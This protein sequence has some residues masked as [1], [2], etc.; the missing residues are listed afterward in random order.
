[1]EQKF[2]IYEF[3]N[4]DGDNSLLAIYD[5]DFLL[6]MEVAEKTNPKI[7]TN[8]DLNNKADIS[9]IVCDVIYLSEKHGVKFNKDY[10]E[11]SNVYI[12]SINFEP[13]N[14]G[15]MISKLFIF[16]G[17]ITA[18][19][20]AFTCNKTGLIVGPIMFI[21]GLIANKLFK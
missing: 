8:K 12:Y 18:I 6:L 11:E 7:F 19:V 21:G 10:D 9:R 4:N 3:T 5:K 15:A 1:M 2:H 20:C 16:A 17:I 14:I 13:I